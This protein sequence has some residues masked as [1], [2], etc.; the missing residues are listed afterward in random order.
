MHWD[1]RVKLQFFWYI[2]TNNKER[3][4]QVLDSITL[5]KVGDNVKQNDI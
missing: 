5:D 4:A 3:S 1:T 2:I